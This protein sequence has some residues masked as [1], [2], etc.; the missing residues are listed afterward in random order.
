MGPLHPSVH[1]SIHT[2]YLDA[3]PKKHSNKWRLI[4][5]LSHPVH[6]SI[7]DGVNKPTCSLTYMYMRFDEV[8][9]EVLSLSRG[10]RLTK[11][12]IENAFRNVPVHPHDRHLLGLSWNGKSYIDAV[13][14][15]GLGSAPK[16]FNALADTLQRIAEQCGI[17]YLRHYLDDLITAGRPHTVECQ[18]NLALLIALCNQ[19]GFPMSVDK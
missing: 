3:I 4:L 5:D 7:N 1:S 15:F 10:C 6:H 2:S 11:I 12:N 8:V 19:L 17:S 18:T 13:L 9:H 16:I 14:P